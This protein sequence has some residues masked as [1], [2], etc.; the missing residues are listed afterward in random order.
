MEKKKPELMLPAGNL[1]MLK[2]AVLNGADAVYFGAKKFN[3]RMPAENF[4]E[5]NMKDAIDFCHLHKKKAYLTLNTLIKDSEMEDAIE[6]AKH[7]YEAGIDAIIVQ[8]LGLIKVLRKLLPELELDASTQMTC[9]N[10][11]GAKFLEGIG[12]KKI[13]LARELS[14]NEIKEIKKSTKAKIE[15]FVHG[16][17]CFSY[18]GQC[19][20]SSFAFNK[21]GNRGMCLQPCRLPYSMTP[22][23]NQKFTGRKSGYVLS[24]KDLMTIDKVKELID[25][26]VGTFKIEGRLKGVG[27]AAA[28]AKAYRLAIDAALGEGKGPT[29]EDIDLVKIAFLRENT[30]GYA[31]GEEEMTSPESSARKGVLAAEVLGFNKELITL[32]LHEKLQ[33]WDKLSLINGDEVKNFNVHKIYKKGEEIPR[34]FVGEFIAVE[35]SQ[36]PYLQKGDK[37]YFTWTQKLN[38]FAY[39]SLARSKGADYNLDVNVETGKK[40][41]ATATFGGKKL[42]IEFDFTPAE[43]RTAQT[44]EGM[45]K[46]KL[47]KSNDFFEPKNFSC[48]IRGNPFVPLSQLRKLKN[49]I[50]SKMREELFGANRKKVD[51]KEF[52]EKKK[53]IFSLIKK[54]NKNIDSQNVQKGGKNQ[55]IIIFLNRENNEISSDAKKIAGS[56]V[57]YD[58]VGENEI[59]KIGAMLGG[60]NVFVKPPNIQSDNSLEEFEK[61]YIL[62]NKKIMCSNLGA[63]QKTIQNKSE[64]LVDRE[65]NIFNSF[66]VQ[67]MVEMGAQKI[68]PSVELS[69]KEIENLAFGE[70]LAPLVFFYPVLMTSKAYSKQ[71]KMREKEW[72]LEDRKKFEYKISFDREGILRIYN[73]MPV[74]MIFELEKFSRFDSIALDFTETKKEEAAQIL[75]YLEEKLAGKN[76][77]KK[78][79][80]FTRGHYTDSVE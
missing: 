10:S 21:S 11:A 40:I 29:K 23:G 25:A 46:E 24:M 72:S 54:E 42:K 56:T 61:K 60:K 63:L 6:I 79:A 37:L 62:K 39:S 15:C 22:N 73:P 41:E 2:A 16:A 78:Y 32:K 58:L 47:F 35:P 1:D 55:E 76:P 68:V 30:N 65:L 43:S 64:F 14:L 49:F 7:A 8:D 27:Y 36:R 77:Q 31:F 33:R 59:E 19:L 51:E 74:D 20:F 52:E 28:T 26:G 75:A 50:L 45:L 3:A 4:S 44:S 18:S 80:K 66:S 5:E 69:L 57:L 12:I 48:K 34:A 13:V 70:K 67:M 38:D 53:K 71:E 17:L 9:H